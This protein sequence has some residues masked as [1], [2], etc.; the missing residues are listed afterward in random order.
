MAG[1]TTDVQTIRNVT[2]SS[3]INLQVPSALNVD[4]LLSLPVPRREIRI[5]SAV[6]LN[7]T[8]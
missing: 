2:L 8:M 5:E 6:I 4:I 3:G 7:V 1:Y